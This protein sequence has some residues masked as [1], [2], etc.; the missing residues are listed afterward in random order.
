MFSSFLVNKNKNKNKKENETGAADDDE[1]DRNNTTSSLKTH[2]KRN[3]V[4][5]NVDST[6]NKTTKKTGGASTSN[7]ILP[8]SSNPVITISGTQQQQQQQQQQQ[9]TRKQILRT[10]LG[11]VLCVALIVFLISLVVN[12]V[13]HKGLPD[14]DPTKVRRAIEK[15]GIFGVF[16]YIVGFGLAELLHLPGL[17]FVTAG[18]MCWGHFNGWVLAMCMAPISCTVSFLVVRRV[19]GQALADVNFSIVKRMMTHLDDRPL[20]TVFALRSM[21][22]LAPAINYILALSTV[23]L[24]DF[25]LGT[26]L[27]LI[28][29]L[30]V[31][32]Y[33]ID[34]LINYMGWGLKDSI[35]NVSGV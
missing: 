27:G 2:L 24:R 29:P 32:V 6:G 7:D 30:T 3:S 33:F 11:Q 22:F 9:K 12:T 14:I 25:V 19:G 20:M 28:T 23:R 15:A 1:V 31:A 13:A 8:V 4:N 5:V 21:F 35:L 34:N 10:N 18:V 17:V 16:I 26:V